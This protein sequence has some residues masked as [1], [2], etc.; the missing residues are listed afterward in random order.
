VDLY[1]KHGRCIP[2]KIFIHV[3]EILFICLSYWILFQGVGGFVRDVIGLHD[4]GDGTGRRT[5]IFVFNIVIFLR[6]AMTMFFLLQRTIPWAESVSIPSAFALYYVGFSLFVLSSSQPIDELDYCAIALFIV[7]CTLNSGS[8]LLRHRWKKDPRHH[9]RIYTQGLFRYSMHIN[10]FGG[11]LWVTAYA[12]VTRNWYSASIPAFL[13]SFFVFYNIPKLDAYL[14]KKY[15]TDFE[16][17][18]KQTKKFIPFLY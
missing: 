9:D 13:F 5:I 7:G 17:Y 6:L 2:Q 14:H 18:A 1:G 15:G 3:L 4:A 12:L 11:L 10:Y 16:E 8:E